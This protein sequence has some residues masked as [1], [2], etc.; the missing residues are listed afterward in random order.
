MNL[1]QGKHLRI[2]DPGV[3]DDL[4]TRRMAAIKDLA[5]RHRKQTSLSSQLSLAEAVVR[6]FDGAALADPVRGQIVGAI[7]KA[8][9]SFLDE[10]DVDLDL[11]IVAILSAAAAIDTSSDTAATQ[12]SFLAS[13]LSLGLSFRG[14]VADPKLEVLRSE[15]LALARSRAAKSSVKSRERGVIPHPLDQ[16]NYLRAAAVMVENARLDREE[17]DLLWFV[18]NDWSALADCRISTSSPAVSA[19]VSGIETAGLLAETAARAHRDL[20]LRN[21]SDTDGIRS[22]RQLADEV[23]SLRAAVR[24]VLSRALNSIERSPTIFPALAIATMESSDLG[25]ALPTGINDA[26]EMRLIDW[27]RR[28]VDEA[29]LLRQMNQ[30]I[31]LS[32]HVA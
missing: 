30:P 15:L 21:L 5:T 23:I 13:A 10:G 9:P 4:V 29:S 11:A 7:R 2:I 27:C 1:D 6:A 14:E 3:S 25:A 16:T 31:D 24:A 22:A 19:I 26:I 17:L 12:M 8:A 32:Q 28:V 18:I 20:A